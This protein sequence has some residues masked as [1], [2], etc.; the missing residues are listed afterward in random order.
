MGKIIVVQASAGSGKTHYLTGFFLKTILKE[1]TDYFS[2][3]LA[4][5][6]TNKATAEMK[7]RIIRELHTLASGEHSDYM[8]LLIGSSHYS[9]QTIRNKTKLILKKILHD[10]SWFSIETIDSFFQRVIRAFTREMGLPGNYRIE[11]EVQPVLEFAV[12]QLMG[13]LSR[14]TPNLEWLVSFADDKIAEGKSWDIRLDLMNLGRQLF[15]EDFS[16]VA[17]VL[18]ERLNDRPALN[19]FRNQLRNQI[20]T[21]QEYM[22]TGG[23]K[24]LQLM[25]EHGVAAN[26]LYQK[27]RGVYGFFE[28]LAQGQVNE[29]NSYVLKCLESPDS[30]IPGNPDDT[31]PFRELII[32]ELHPLLTQLLEFWE[33]HK[34]YYYSS[35]AI[36]RN[37]YALGILSDL[38]QH[39]VKYRHEKNIFLLSDAPV[40]IDKII[41]ENDAPFIYEKMGN[42][43]RNFL[44]DEFQDTSHLQWKNFRPLIENSLSAGNDC[45]LVGDVKQSIYRWRNS[46]LEILARQ[47]DRQ[48]GKEQIRHE[49]LD[50]NWRSSGNIVQF[51]NLFFNQAVKTVQNSLLATIS[52]SPGSDELLR[53]MHERIYDNVTQQIR[54]DAAGKGMVRVKFFNAEDTRKQPGL[55]EDYLLNHINEL[56][57]SGFTPGDITFLVR[58]RDEGKVLADFLIAGNT[59]GLFL[60]N[61]GVIS[62]ESLF[63]SASNA[64]DLVIAALQYL[65]DPDDAVNRG[66]LLGRIKDQGTPSRDASEENELTFRFGET[67]AELFSQSLPRALEENRNALLSLPL[68]DLIEEL[69]RIFMLS[70]QADEKA[71]M[72]ALLDI[73]HEFSNLNNSGLP[74]FLEY[75]EEEGSTRSIVASESRSSVR[76]MTIHRAKGLEFRAVIIPFCNW[77]LDQKAGTI[78]WGKTQ[79]SPFEYLPLIPLNYSKRLSRTI[80]ADEYYTEFCK[81]AIDNINLLYVAFTRAIDS[82]LIIAEK[83]K[84]SKEGKINSVNQLLGNVLTGHNHGEFTNGYDPENQE[85]VF[86]TP[87]QQAVK[88]ELSEDMEL[89]PFTAKPVTDRLFFD[90]RGYTFFREQSQFSREQVLRGV[91]FHGILS[92]VKSPPDIHRAVEKAVF[93]GLITVPEK[94]HLLEH[95]EAGLSDPLVRSWFSS[96]AEILTETEIISGK[97]G[98]KRPDR[99][100]LFSDEWHVIDYKFG[101]EDADSHAQQVR[102]Y[103]SLLSGMNGPKVKGFLWYVSSGKVIP[104]T[105][106]RKEVSA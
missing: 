14:D 47:I 36:L 86:G 71:Y 56:L 38:H 3:I 28:Q 58:T 11:T 51:N 8:K 65:A 104:V 101:S 80:F 87:G 22:V 55:F 90:P 21:V 46:D 45:L 5:T 57:K 44:I 53:T 102:E 41:D 20:G 31:V 103:M 15:N 43:Y 33:N 62:E 59:T 25:G 63:V 79:G 95:F 70:D 96:E 7:S 13:N 26:D 34:L 42:R 27:R 69:Y 23:R 89:K 92:E 66:R 2:H 74:G 52:G 72:D 85:I 106:S 77:S 82:L 97:S 49:T 19:Q 93:E 40:F 61:L 75:W 68:Y 30:W 35:L 67:H 100:V 4:V 9:E 83:T 16:R 29:P 94:D 64:V 48:Y 91:I 60:T 17:S 24:A 37:L 105:G 10:Y 99:V 39:V 84:E 54:S 32:H 98:I 81:S 88:D 50:T 76:I 1:K 12:D 78:I 6:F 73:V 18:N